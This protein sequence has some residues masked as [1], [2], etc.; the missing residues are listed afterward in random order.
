MSPFFTASSCPFFFCTKQY[1]HP[2]LHPTY[3]SKRMGRLHSTIWLPH[4]HAI[5]VALLENG[6]EN[7]GHK[8][9]FPVGLD[10][11]LQVVAVVLVEAEA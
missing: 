7:Y 3:V 5:V 1:R 9:V 6:L 8:A 4:L 10:I 11:C 2:W